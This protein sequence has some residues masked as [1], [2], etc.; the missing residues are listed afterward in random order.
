MDDNPAWLAPQEARDSGFL[1]LPS[2]QPAEDEALPL[3]PPLANEALPTLE[4]GNWVEMNTGRGWQ[5]SQ[6]TWASPHGTLFLFT[7]P[8]G[9]TQSM[10]R[11]MR[12]RMMREGLMRVLSTQPVVAGAL[13]EVA[14]TA[15]RNTV[16]TPEAD[17]GGGP[18]PVT[19]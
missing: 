9:S 2:E 10:T 3:L 17:A 12:E 6:L 14:R 11:R 16:S 4:L 19:G 1:T 8:D 7:R 5:R 18:G 15:L 13:D